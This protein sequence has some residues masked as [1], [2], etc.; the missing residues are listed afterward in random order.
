MFAQTFTVSSSAMWPVPD[1]PVGKI[2]AVKEVVTLP[3]DPVPAK[4]VTETEEPK[5]TVALPTAP[6]PTTVVTST[7]S[8]S[9]IELK[10]FVEKG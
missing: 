6:V 3:T 8:V 2:T 7:N 9:P 1:T 10:P 5:T 4:P